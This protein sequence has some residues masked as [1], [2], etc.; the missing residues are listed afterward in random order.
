MSRASWSDVPGRVLLAGAGAWA[1]GWIF[2]AWLGM[3]LLLALASGI[4]G[5]G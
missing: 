4:Y 1:L 5:C 3:D 2:Q